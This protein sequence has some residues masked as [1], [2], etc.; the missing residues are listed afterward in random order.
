VLNQLGRVEVSICGREGRES[1]GAGAR[2]H[3][4]ERNGGARIP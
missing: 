2:V 4:G 3:G 1:G